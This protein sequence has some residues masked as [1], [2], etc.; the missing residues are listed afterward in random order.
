PALQ[1]R[2][3][4]SPMRERI[5][6]FGYRRDAPRIVAAC[7]AAVLPSLRREGLPKTVIEAMAYGV[8]PV[9]TNVGGSPELVEDGRS[10]R[11]VPPGDARALGAALLE[12]YE[13]PDLRRGFG[14]AARRR[15][16]EEFSIEKTIEQTYELYR[17]LTSDGRAGAG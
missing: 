4:R 15:I 7:D 3:A 13:R 12:L 1:K 17:E 8:A 11:V 5:R 6:V 2:I 10:G 14:S 9:V 16:A